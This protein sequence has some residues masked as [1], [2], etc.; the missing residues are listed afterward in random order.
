MKEKSNNKDGITK[1]A[2]FSQGTTIQLGNSKNINE[3][4]KR[5]HGKAVQ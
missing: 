4:G 5:S 2:D 1:T 3:K